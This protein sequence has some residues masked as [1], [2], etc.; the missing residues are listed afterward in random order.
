MTRWYAV[1]DFDFLLWE[2]TS[3][4]SRQTKDFAFITK[5][6]HDHMVMIRIIVVLVCLTGVL[7]QTVLRKSGSCP[8]SANILLVGLTNFL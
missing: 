4:S 7:A 8:A 5:L 3:Q 2:C 6:N 1:L